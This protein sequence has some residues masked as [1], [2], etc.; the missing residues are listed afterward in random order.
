VWAAR[1]PARA[2]RGARRADGPSA[3]QC[4]V[5]DL[6]N[7][8]A[9]IGMYQTMTKK[10]AI[11]VQVGGGPCRGAVP[12]GRAAPSP[13][14]HPGDGCGSAPSPPETPRRALLTPVSPLPPR[15]QRK[16][17]PSNSF[18]VVVVVKTEDEVC[19]GPLPYYPLARDA[20]PGTAGG[21]G[22]AHHRGLRAGD[23]AEP[24]ARACFQTS[25]WTSTTGGRCWR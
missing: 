1:P 19:G 7:N 23:A 21:W 12:G 15:E 25:P 11:T 8:V 24:P 18:Y 3:P 20:P 5:Y 6:D 4:P 10:A 13:R 14:A 17:F 16:D 9:F 22:S 2:T